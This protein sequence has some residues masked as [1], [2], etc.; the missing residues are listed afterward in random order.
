MRSLPPFPGFGASDP[1]SIAETSSEVTV[2]IL[3]LA[4]RLTPLSFRSSPGAT[5]S[6]MANMVK[7]KYGIL[8]LIPNQQG[9]KN[10][11]G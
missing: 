1:S 11:M 7:L 8:S 4:M 10:V 6:G 3:S 2:G 5:F 9:C